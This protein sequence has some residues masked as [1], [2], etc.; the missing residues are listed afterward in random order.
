MSSVVIDQPSVVTD[1]LY[2]SSAM[3]DNYLVLSIGLFIASLLFGCFWTLVFSVPAI[4]FSMKVRII[5]ATMYPAK[6]ASH[7]N[8]N[9][10]VI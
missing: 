2:H 3:N 8:N 5:L 7:S 1:K 4:I 6:N 9:V 10:I